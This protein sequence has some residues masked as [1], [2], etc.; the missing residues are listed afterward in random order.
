MC[1]FALPVHVCV[2]ECVSGPVMKWSCGKVLASDEGCIDWWARRLAYR[3][4]RWV[5]LQ[6]LPIGTLS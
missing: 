1:D 4:G 2:P 5:M 3:L 6:G